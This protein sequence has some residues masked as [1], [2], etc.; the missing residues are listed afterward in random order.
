MRELLNHVL[1]LLPAGGA[2]FQEWLL[3]QLL[4]FG[5]GIFLVPLLM[6]AV[7][8]L[9]KFFKHSRAPGAKKEIPVPAREREERNSPKTSELRRPEPIFV[10]EP[11]EFKPPAPKKRGAGQKSIRFQDFSNLAPLRTETLNFAGE[12]PPKPSLSEIAGNSAQKGPRPEGTEDLNLNQAGEFHHQ[13]YHRFKE[14]FILHLRDHLHGSIRLEQA[15][16][17]GLTGRPVADNFPFIF[18]KNPELLFDDAAHREADSIISELYFHSIRTDSFNP[19]VNADDADVSAAIVNYAI[20]RGKHHWVYTLC[21]ACVDAGI[22][23]ERLFLLGAILAAAENRVEIAD[24]FYATCAEISPHQEIT[25]QFLRSG[26]DP[27]GKLTNQS[28]LTRKETLWL[29]WLTSVA[30]ADYL[31]ERRVIHEIFNNIYGSEDILTFLCALL[32]RGKLYL[33]LRLLHKYRNRNVNFQNILMRIYFRNGKYLHF[34]R[35][36]RDMSSRG[37]K[38]ALPARNYWYEVYYCLYRLNREGD[39]LGQGKA[40]LENFNSLDFPPEGEQRRFLNHLRA[41]DNGRFEPDPGSAR[42][43]D[44]LA[45]GLYYASLQEDLRSPEKRKHYVRVILKLF[46]NNLEEQK[47]LFRYEVLLRAI[48]WGFLYLEDRSYMRR[49]IPYLE[50]M[51]GR[52]PSLRI[53]IG[54]YFYEQGESARAVQYLEFSPRHPIVLHRLADIYSQNGDLT[55][56]EVV[57]TKLLSWYPNDA[58]FWYNYGLLLEKNN[59][60]SDASRAFHRA[61]DLDPD[62]DAAQERISKMLARKVGG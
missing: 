3:P 36:F 22:H 51:A 19:V 48:F 27:R 31:G 61:L 18:W 60:Q 39:Y 25:Y 11:G 49:F 32:T 37:A 44:L 23:F 43:G 59:R 1:N 58:V 28:Q 54:L 17:P 55:Q 34:L 41:L 29:D 9:H 6:L 16:R 56:A 14:R 4:T 15:F 21:F 8:E 30:R 7:L 57:Y 24:Y 12:Q 47:D 62:L 52:N 20:W 46:R 40:L 26:R 35:H 38:P 53:F 2:S 45:H 33:A 10:P 13:R 50:S 42:Y 5:A